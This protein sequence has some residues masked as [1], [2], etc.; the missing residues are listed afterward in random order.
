MTMKRRIG[1][2]L[3][4]A[5]LL[6]WSCAPAEIDAPAGVSEEEHAVHVTDDVWRLGDWL[7][8]VL[9]D[10]TAELTEFGGEDCF[11]EAQ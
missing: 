6:V 2:L 9:D 1:I 5:V 10:G 11:W 4:A 7:Y 8:R 3:W